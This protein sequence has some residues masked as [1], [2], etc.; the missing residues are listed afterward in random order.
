MS[1]ISVIR[2]NN[3]IG[4]IEQEIKPGKIN[5]IKGPNGKGKTSVIEALEK[6]FTNKSRRTEIIRHGEEEATLYVELD[7]GLSVDRRIRADKADYLKIRKDNE[8][9]NSTEKFLKQL[10]NGD[11]FRP[12]DWVNL[13]VKEQTKS[14]LSMLEIGW[15]KENIINWFGELTD[16][17]DYTEHI[18]II[19]KNI[20]TKYYND[21][22]EVNREIKE[23]EARIKSI[24]DDLPP[25]Y[26][27]EQWQ[28]VNVQEYYNKVKEAQDIN[29]WIAEAKGLQENYN[30]KVESIGANAENKKS[31]ITLKYKTEREDIK[32]LI[33]LSNSRIGKA[34]DVISNADRELDLTIR[35]IKNKCNHDVEGNY[36]AYLKDVEA[37]EQEMKRRKANLD[38]SYKFTIDAIKNSSKEEIEKAKDNSIKMVSEQKDLISIHNS[39]IAA[40][41]QELIGLEDKELSEKEAVANNAI[42]EIEKEKLRIGKASKYL[43]EHQEIDIEPLQQEANKVQEMVSY[44][45]EWN[46]I[47]EIRDNQLA[48]KEEYAE[49]LTARINKARN[50]PGELLQTAKM[51]I[52]GISVDVN[53]RV[54]IN[55]TLIDGLSD[56][57]KLEL[58]MKVAKAQCGELKVIC[59]DKWESLDKNSQ[60]KL[61]E[62]MFED[63]YQYFVTEVTNTDSNQVEIEKI[64]DVC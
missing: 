5:I 60:A 38:E 33:A 46:R 59:I 28:S 34:K 53:G 16:T 11:I 35:E 18:L 36:Q 32:D 7:D 26:D 14:L 43:E 48:P 37:L 45:R 1:K 49:V 23:L 55:N 42:A 17:I 56:G 54:R 3:C 62:E 6:T 2:C 27:G 10:V 61:F 41:E 20:E 15:N 22:A 29:R 13:S 24:I 44:L 47:A 30:S 19:L 40:K 58:A 52:E 64:G 51:P 50:L 31:S 25:E 4:I 21:R 12:M 9:I 8:G 57:E 39:K 63:D